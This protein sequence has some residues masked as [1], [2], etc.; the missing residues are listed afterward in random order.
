MANQVIVETSAR[1]VHLSQAE[2]KIITINQSWAKTRLIIDGFVIYEGGNNQ[3]IRLHLEQ[4]EHLI[5]VEYVNNWHTT[6]F[7]LSFL[8]DI[9]KLS[10]KEI[11]T[12][13]TD[14]AFGEYEVYYIG[15]YESNNKD[16]SLIL[17]VKKSDKRIVLV[18]NSY[19][20]VKWRIANPFKT[21][22][23]AI[24][25]G[26]YSPGAMIGGDIDTTT[27]LLPMA[28]QIGSHSMGPHN[29]TCHAGT[30]HCEGREDDILATKQT[31]ERLGQA[32]M[33]GATA[34]YS[35]SELTVPQVVINESFVLEQERKRQ[36]IS[37]LQK[38]CQQRSDPDFETMFDL[39]R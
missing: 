18:L 36:E 31:I 21:D 39:R 38:A 6:E 3:E 13:L 5:E 7:S 14:A 8:D 29:C 32:K 24:V 27:L 9:S 22:I 11:A 4:G 20:P 37:E 30:F 34:T 33:T 10:L 15:V 16:L 12:R 28:D 19:S 23:R 2:V 17:N 26:S 35:A 25:Y 1:H